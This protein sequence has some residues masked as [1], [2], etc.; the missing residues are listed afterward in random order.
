MSER[1]ARAPRPRTVSRISVALIA[2]PLALLMFPSS[3]TAGIIAA[4]LSA[5]LFVTRA[6]AQ[7]VVARSNAEQLRAL[8]LVDPDAAALAGLPAV[9]AFLAELHRPTNALTAGPSLREL[10]RPRLGELVARRSVPAVAFATSAVNS[11]LLR[12]AGAFDLDDDGWRRFVDEFGTRVRE[13]L[14]GAARRGPYAAA[15]ACED[16]L[17]TLATTA[18]PAR[19]PAVSGRLYAYGPAEIAFLTANELLAR[20]GPL[21]A[22]YLETIARGE[23]S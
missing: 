2:I 13:D 19:P 21:D 12:Q 23:L 6:V 17:E 15:I 18:P 10:L 7:Q 20:T 9:T 14:V 11:A 22:S 4:V 3:R 8:G 5:L 1:P 16:Y